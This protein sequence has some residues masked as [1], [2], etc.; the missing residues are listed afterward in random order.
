MS[1]KYVILSGRAT[2]SDNSDDECACVNVESS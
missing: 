1:P 2:V